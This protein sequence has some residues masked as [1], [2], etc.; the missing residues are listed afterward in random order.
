ML[1]NLRFSTSTNKLDNK[2]DE[3]QKDQSKKAFMRQNL[4]N[5]RYRSPKKNIIKFFNKKSPRQAR[6]RGLTYAQRRAIYRQRQL[7]KIKH[8]KYKMFFSKYPQYIKYFLERKFKNV[9]PADVRFIMYYSNKFPKEVFKK[10]KHKPK[11]KPGMPLKS[12]F[13]LE[14]LYRVRFSVK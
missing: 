12:F 9:D 4:Q 6:L 3:N 2:F 14:F 13:F 5:N 10:I 1:K 8:L 7:N 11:K